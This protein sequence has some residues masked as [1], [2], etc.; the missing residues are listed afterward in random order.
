MKLIYLFTIMI[1]IL[2]AISLA[3]RTPKEKAAAMDVLFESYAQPGA[4]GASVV[5][6]KNGKVLF[7]KAYGLANLEEKI[8]SA[9]STNYRL[10]SVT[11]Q[12]T[13]MAIM[14]LV[15]RKKLSYDDRLTD[16]FPGFP[17]YG[18]Q[19]TVRHLLNHTSGLI[20]YE[21]VMDDN[22]TTPLTDHDVLALMM[23]QDHTHFPPGS[24]YR[25]SNGA[26]VLLGLIVE[27][28]S[29][30]T[31]P[32]FLRKNIFAP[33]RMNHTVLYDRDDHSDRRRAYGYSKRGDVFTRTDQSLTSSTRGDGTVY[34]SV[35]DLFKWDQALY[36]AR[37]VSAATLNQ[38]FTP[39]TKVD[40]DTGYGFGWFIE[41]RQGRRTVW[42][43]GNTIGFTQFIRRYPDQRF[44]I[45][46]QA[47]R[48]DAEL[49][50]IADSIEEIFPVSDKP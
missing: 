23:K 9:T 32:E 46:V 34:S 43:S 35:D 14:I 19:I 13:A 10:A 29:G 27:K 21:D 44:T 18:K 5:V 4:P 25:Y 20:A 2:A 8:P 22:A 26:Y 30:L 38:A 45:I 16:L 36:T 37:L 15:E 28:A 7:K 40:E 12:F 47:N 3:P 24:Q 11:K 31:F 41:D 49:A 6:I 33:L 42:H 48:N 50:K 1:M 17:E 39:G